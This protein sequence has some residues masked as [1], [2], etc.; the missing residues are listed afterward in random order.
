M[1]I[2]DDIFYLESFLSDYEI[3]ELEKII[4][5]NKEV[6]NEILSGP[7]AGGYHTF[8]STEPIMDSIAN[9]M[10]KVLKENNFVF[11]H[12][13]PREEIQFVG[14]GSGQSV[15]IDGDG[16]G[17]DVSWGLVAYIS[18]PKS[19]SGGE[20]YYPDHDIEI[21]PARGSLAIHRGNINHGVKTV[22]GDTRFVI[23][24]FTGAAYPQD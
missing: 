18:D 5:A 9:R 20:I 3:E 1:W 19:Y 14:P 21:K 15:H 17:K 8:S 6:I 13:Y 4:S 2:N 11:G 23:V 24:A 22:E 10:F 16:S 12:F 7:N